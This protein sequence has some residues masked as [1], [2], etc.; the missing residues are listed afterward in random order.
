[1]D[2]DNSVLADSPSSGRV[3]QAA[4]VSN[5]SKLTRKR[6]IRQANTPP[7]ISPEPSDRIR[8]RKLGLHFLQNTFGKITIGSAL[9]DRQR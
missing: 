4:H 9:T 7:P 2:E 1:M 5:G 6:M 3:G 8:F